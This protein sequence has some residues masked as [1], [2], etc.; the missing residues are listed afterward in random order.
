MSHTIKT[1]VAF[2][3]AAFWVCSL[4]SQSISTDAKTAHDVLTSGNMHK[5]IKHYTEL[6]KVNANDA[7]YNAFIGYAYLNSNIDKSKAV[8]HLE[9]AAKHKTANAYIHYD[10]GRAYM[11]CYRFDEAIASFKN[12]Q[13][14]VSKE[15]EGD[16][17]A[18]RCIEMCENAKMLIPLR[19]NVAIK[20]LGEEINTEF[21]DFNAYIDESET[22]LYFSTKRAK[23]SPAV[24]DVDGFKT[25]DIY[26]ST[27]NGQTWE[28]PKRLSNTINSAYIEESVG[29]SADGNTLFIYVDNVY[30]VDDIFVS[31]KTKKN[32]QK[33]ENMGINTASK[34]KAAAIS[35]D[36][37]WLFFSSDR[38]GGYGGF[39][40]YYCKKLPNGDWSF[41]INAGN[42]IN[43]Q[44]DDNF[45]Y[46]APNGETFY[47]A[48]QG[49]NSMGGYDLFVS[50]W[51]DENQSFSMP[52]NLGF[53][54]N[55]PDDNKTISV[56][57]S[58]RYAYISDFRE[59]GL[60]DL[61]IFK[62]T[63]L[64]MPAP[65]YI[66]NARM[67]SA[68]SVLVAPE[69]IG[70]NDYRIEVK[71]VATREVIGVYRPNNHNAQFSIVLKSGF[72][73]FD[74]YDNNEKTKTFEY[75]IDDRESIGNNLTI[76]IIVKKND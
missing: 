32:F 55:T 19:S 3:F 13:A 25:S 16:I 15:D 42:A 60:G 18:A 35:P 43:T 45:P 4:S 68:D 49:H 51:N 46:I 47:F 62:V 39:D 44:Y 48:S 20:N 12:F 54:I 58:G 75:L 14:K 36:G 27:F 72:Y 11:L 9:K 37:N 34:E 74:F 28:K 61:D 10:L 56:S 24:D 30:G 52:D 53:P 7:D 67:M 6:L 31:E 8:E 22:T 50:T 64:D 2:V 17:P 71:D 29:L 21:P 41:P 59:N 26:F 69:N 65:N 73:L 5:A 23:N 66:V 63:F 40:I 38:P 57:K 1:V 70:S 33:S 76:D